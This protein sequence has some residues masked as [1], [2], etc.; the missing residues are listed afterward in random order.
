MK[1]SEAAFWEYY[2][3]LSTLDFVIIWLPTTMEWAISYLV[4][5]QHFFSFLSFSCNFHSKIALLAIPNVDFMISRTIT[6]IIQSTRKSTSRDHCSTARIRKKSQH[7]LRYS[8]FLVVHTVNLMFNSPAGS[9]RVEF[10][11]SPISKL[12]FEEAS[13]NNFKVR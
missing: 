12:F 8:N 2:C 1:R 6:I 9:N 10:D 3:W 5:S 4:F 7:W 11:I 13:T